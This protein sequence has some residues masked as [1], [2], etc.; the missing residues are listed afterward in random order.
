MVCA[1]AARKGGGV[2]LICSLWIL[3]VSERNRR[4]NCGD[5]GL[6]RRDFNGSLARCSH[7]FTAQVLIYGKTGEVKSPEIHFSGKATYQ[8]LPSIVN[9]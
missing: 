2:Q 6:D 8:E 9:M 1:R 7:G 5:L 4:Q 3:P